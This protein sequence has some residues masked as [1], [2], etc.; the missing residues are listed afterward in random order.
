MEAISFFFKHQ[1]LIWANYNDPTA[2]SRESWLIREIIP[3]LNGIQVSER[4]SFSQINT[5]VKIG[6]LY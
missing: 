4:I 5:N 1:P 2:T 3:K 6:K